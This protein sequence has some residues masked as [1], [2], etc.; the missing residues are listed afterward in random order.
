M[1]AAPEKEKR[2]IF[3]NP[4][5][6]TS[7]ALLVALLYVGWVFYSR[8]QENQAYEERV[9]QREAKKREED[10]RAVELMGGNRFEIVNFYG[11]PSIIRNDQSAALCY[12]VSNTKKVRLDPPDANVWPSLSRCF[13]VS[14][15]KTTTYTLTIED[16]EGHVK[17]A[18]VKIIVE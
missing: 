1:L 11:T 10:E 15:K 2:S 7:T 14:P 6:Y 8:W 4:L 13:H 17:S 5:L 9:A 18:T 12:S 3:R 16:T